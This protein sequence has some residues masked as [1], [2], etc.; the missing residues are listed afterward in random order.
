[1]PVHTVGKVGQ[2]FGGS[3]STSNTRGRPMRGALQ[4]TTALIDSLDHGFVF[5]T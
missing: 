3:G 4:Q 2:L 5:T 1:M